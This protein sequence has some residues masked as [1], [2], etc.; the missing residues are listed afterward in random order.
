MIFILIINCLLLWLM[1]YQ[2]IR[3]KRSY[4]LF[5]NSD[6]R[7]SWTKLEL[8]DLFYF[9]HSWKANVSRAKEYWIILIRSQHIQQRMMNFLKIERSSFKFFDI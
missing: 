5:C 1:L 8:W 9:S 3:V 7:S 2:I 6:A 4:I